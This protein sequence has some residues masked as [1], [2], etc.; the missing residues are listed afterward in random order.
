MCI[1]N[2]SSGNFLCLNE[3]F[4]RLP[5]FSAY[6]SW[7][8][9]QRELCEVWW[10]ACRDVTLVARGWKLL[11]GQQ[12]NQI[13]SSNQIFKTDWSDSPNNNAGKSQSRQFMSASRRNLF[14]SVVFHVDLLVAEQI[15]LVLR[16]TSVTL[17]FFIVCHTASDT[18][19][20]LKSDIS[21]QSGPTV[22]Q[23]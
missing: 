4:V 6:E 16:R 14:Y 2:C 7:V 8:K 22:K 15:L 1:K 12:T 10:N 20:T 3:S 23:V 18:E 9:L 5:L 11:L 17:D 21:C 19:D 13:C